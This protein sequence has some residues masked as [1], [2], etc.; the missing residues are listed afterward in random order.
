MPHRLRHDVPDFTARATPNR[1]VGDTPPAFPPSSADTG[2]DP[3]LHPHLFLGF[4]PVERLPAGRA[5]PGLARRGEDPQRAMQFLCA[6]GSWECSFSH[7][8]VHTASALHCAAVSSRRSAGRRLLGPVSLSAERTCWRSFI[9]ADAGSGVSW[10]GFRRIGMGLP[11]LQRT[12]VQEFPAAAQGDPGWAP[13]A[14]GFSFSAGWSLRPCRFDGRAR[15][16]SFGIASGL[17]GVIALL[18]VTVALPRSISTS[19]SLH[20]CSPTSPAL[21]WRRRNHLVYGLPNHL[22]FYAKRRCQAGKPFA[23]SSNPPRREAASGADRP[24]P[25]S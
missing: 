11:A 14:I 6:V 17:M 15:G 20:R 24:G 19:S 4:S 5:R 1:R 3:V 2:D 23:R 18:I 12:I 22:L 10:P 16:L 9:V 8:L 21:N 7:P 25:T 13:M